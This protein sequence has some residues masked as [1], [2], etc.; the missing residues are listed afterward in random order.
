MK[1][2]VLF[3][4]NLF[5]LSFFSSCQSAELCFVQVV[6]DT[7]FNS[8]QRISLLLL[9]KESLH[10]YSIDFAYQSSEL[11]KPSQIAETRN[12]VAAIN[13]GFFDMDS[14]GSVTY[15]EISDSVISRTRSSE[16]KWAVPDSLINGALILNKNHTLEI[17]SANKEQFYEDSKRESF[18]MVSGPLLISDSVAQNL[19]DMK[20]AS[21][22]HPRTCVGI[23][24]ESIIFMTIDGRSEQAYGM[25]LIEVQ[26]YM[27]DLGCTEAINLDGGGS[28]CMWIDNKGVVNIPCD[29]AGERPVANALLILEK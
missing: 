27:L 21:M 10:R 15:F 26:K 9:D 3:I 29:K 19:P 18:V 25:S 22:R 12:A 28:T 24:K 1:F 20:F 8:P 16:L 5:L 11:L 23:T 6:T 7:L 17:E 14:G 13:G 4:L 2:A